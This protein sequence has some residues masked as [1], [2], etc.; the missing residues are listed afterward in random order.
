M[1]GTYNASARSYTGSSFSFVNTLEGANAM[2]LVSGAATSGGS[3]ALNGN[4]HTYERGMIQI[5][6]ANWNN[7]SVA[8]RA[9]SIIHE[10]GH[11]FNLVTGLGS[12]LIVYDVDPLTG[13]GSDIDQEWNRE[14]ISRKCGL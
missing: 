7:M 2:A 8:S 12:S 9:A 4:G 1:T 10:L 14:Y 13:D 11:L 5:N 6:A 3:T